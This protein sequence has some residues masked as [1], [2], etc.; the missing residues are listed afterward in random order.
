MVGINIWS[1]TDF[2]FKSTILP[3]EKIPD[4]QNCGKANNSIAATVFDTNLS[5]GIICN[6]HLGGVALDVYEEEEG[7]FFEDFLRLRAPG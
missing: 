3:F 6:S 7:I 4:P 5:S 1:R 2:V